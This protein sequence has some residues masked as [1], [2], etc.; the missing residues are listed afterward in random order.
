MS[1]LSKV[2]CI[3]HIL[4]RE[5]EGKLRTAEHPLVGKVRETYEHW[6]FRLVLIVLGFRGLASLVSDAGQM[7]SGMLPSLH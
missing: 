3:S 1:T 2:D 4:T 6:L 7:I 5:L